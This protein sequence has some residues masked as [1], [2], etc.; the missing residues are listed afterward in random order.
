MLIQSY[1][2]L[3]LD[4]LLKKLWDLESLGITADEPS[5]YDKFESF[6]Q[7]HGNRYVVSLPW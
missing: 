3:Q 4:N 1:D 6:V 5:V 2:S 7:L